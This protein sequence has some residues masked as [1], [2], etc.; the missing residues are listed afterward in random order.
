LGEPPLG[1]EFFPQKFQIFQFFFLLG[2]KNLIGPCQKYPGQRQVGPL[3]IAGLKYVSIESGPISYLGI[4][5][6][7][8]FISLGFGVWLTQGPGGWI[9]RI[10]LL[11]RTLLE[12]V[13]RSVQDWSSNP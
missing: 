1:L 10:I 2:Q 9:G 7:Q 5:G 8:N 11:L 4:F 13:Q 6:P 3:F 12:M